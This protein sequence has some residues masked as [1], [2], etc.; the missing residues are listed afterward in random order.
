MIFFFFFQGFVNIWW[1]PLANMFGRR[2]VFL[3]TTLI[4]MSAGVW[5]GSFTGT[6]QWMGAM[7]LNGVG[8]S[9]YQAVIQL[10][11]CLPS[12]FSIPIREIHYSQANK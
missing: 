11:V 5:L 4:C 1:I 6:G 3:A 10:A 9:A 8:T 12:Q 7:I 2:P